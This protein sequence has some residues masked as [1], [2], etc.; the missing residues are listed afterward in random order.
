MPS[1]GI[2]ALIQGTL[3]RAFARS[4]LYSFPKLRIG[5]FYYKQ[6]SCPREP[7]TRKIVVV[8][9]CFNCKILFLIHVKKLEESP[10]PPGSSEA[11]RARREGPFAPRGPGGPGRGR[12]AARP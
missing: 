8:F 5:P 1:V 7:I 12:S 3:R 6:N 2:I 10:G 9:V 4:H 11:P